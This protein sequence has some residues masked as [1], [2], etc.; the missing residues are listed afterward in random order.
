MATLLTRMLHRDSSRASAL[1]IR[2]TAAPTAPMTDSP[3]VGWRAASVLSITTEP[4][5]SRSAEIA[6]RTGKIRG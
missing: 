6:A 1:V 3:G 5:R 2:I 4:P